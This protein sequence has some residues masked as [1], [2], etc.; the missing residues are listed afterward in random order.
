MPDTIAPVIPLTPRTQSRR[1]AL[2]PETPQETAMAMA[3]YAS[4]CDDAIRQ[5]SR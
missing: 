5:A 2:Y 3:I 1:P 4:L